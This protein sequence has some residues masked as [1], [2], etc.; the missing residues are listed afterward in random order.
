MLNEL[1]IFSPVWYKM[2]SRTCANVYE[3]GVPI[4]NHWVFTNKI[5]AVFGHISFCKQGSKCP[6]SV[7]DVKFLHCPFKETY[8]MEHYFNKNEVYMFHSIVEF[9]QNQYLA[10]RLRPC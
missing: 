7:L 4:S 10:H 9:K 5:V 8:L 6:Q 2:F 3:L 1:T